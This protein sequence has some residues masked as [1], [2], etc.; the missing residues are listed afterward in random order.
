MVNPKNHKNP[1]SDFF[2]LKYASNRFAFH[3]FAWLIQMVVHDGVW[4]DTERMVDRR[5]D[6]SRMHRVLKRC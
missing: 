5:K 4:V 3:Q 1:G 6:V 2:R